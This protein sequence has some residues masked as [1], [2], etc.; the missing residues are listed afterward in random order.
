MYLRNKQMLTSTTDPENSETCKCNEEQNT[1]P[2]VFIAQVEEMQQA[3]V[4][5]LKTCVQLNCSE[6]RKSQ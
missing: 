3:N 4:S 5:P 2:T 1:L 6:S